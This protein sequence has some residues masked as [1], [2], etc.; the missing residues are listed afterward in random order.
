MGFH[1]QRLDAFH[2]VVDLFVGAA[3]LEDDDHGK[4]CP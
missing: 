2:D 4:A 1:A 3:R